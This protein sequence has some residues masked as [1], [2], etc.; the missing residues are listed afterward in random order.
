MVGG[1]RLVYPAI[2]PI[3]FRAA[4]KRH[5]KRGRPLVTREVLVTS[6]SDVMIMSDLSVIGCT[7]RGLAFK[8]AL[9][10]ARISDG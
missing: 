9:D 2:T 8:M 10:E 7:G 6:A 1:R 3:G 4:D 5:G